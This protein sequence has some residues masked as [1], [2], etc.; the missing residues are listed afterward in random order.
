VLDLAHE[1]DRRVA[2]EQQQVVVVTMRRSAALEDRQVMDVAAQHRQQRVE[3]AL[4]RGCR[5]LYRG[6]DARDRRGAVAPSAA[7]RSRRSGP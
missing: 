5:E 1:R 6:H 7:T 4:V 3:A 2:L